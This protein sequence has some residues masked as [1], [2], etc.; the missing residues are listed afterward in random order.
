MRQLLAG[1]NT[2]VPV[3]GA[4][5]YLGTWQTIY[6]AEYDGQREKEILIRIMG[7]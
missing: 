7:Q 3:E 1:H 4:D 2:T 5:L 6:Y